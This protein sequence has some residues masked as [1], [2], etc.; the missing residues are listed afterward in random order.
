LGTTW[1][2][3]RRNAPYGADSTHAPTPATRD[4]MT[5]RHNSTPST[6]EPVHR[7]RKDRQTDGTTR[8]SPTT[9][10]GGESDAVSD[11]VQGDTA[12]ISGCRTRHTLHR[13]YALS[14]NR[15]TPTRRNLAFV[16]V[17]SLDTKRAVG[18][19]PRRSGRGG[20]HTRTIGCLG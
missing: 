15:S 14:A 18:G 5:Q 9:N 1:S 11:A 20:Y 6:C 10:G 8:A 13:A 12:S 19:K 2:L 7:G 3:P 4:G 17:V 16:G